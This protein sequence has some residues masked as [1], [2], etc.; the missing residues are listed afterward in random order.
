MAAPAKDPR[1]QHQE[2][3]HGGR[4]RMRTQWSQLS[5]Q[6]AA[7]WK[8]CETVQRRPG[9]G[10]PGRDDATTMT[11]EREHTRGPACQRDCGCM[12]CFQ[13]GCHPEP[14]NDRGGMRWESCH[15]HVGKGTA[16]VFLRMIWRRAAEDRPSSCHQNPGGLSE[17][18]VDTFQID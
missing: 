16:L 5:L 17:L 8:R 13:C 14:K 9:R 1:A 11:E 18:F 6:P 15:H 12:H 2:Q 7:T 10:R 3:T 4:H